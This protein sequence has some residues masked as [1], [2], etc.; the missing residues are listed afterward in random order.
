MKAS[1]IVVAAGSGVR[2]GAST[3]KAFVRVGGSTIL[4]LTLR[5]VG[6]VPSIGEIVLT[7]PPRMERAAREEAA[8]LELP[9]KIIAGGIERQDSVRLALAMTSAEAEL[10][11]VHDV[12]RP[13]ATAAMFDAALERAAEVG[14]AIVAAPL[15]DT[16]KQV[17]GETI[18]ATVLR[19]NLW[20]AQTPQAFR[21][22]LLIRAHE[23][24]SRAGII[25]TD[26]ADLVERLGATVA[27]V[28]GSSMN[29]KITTPEDL[30]LAEAIAASRA[31][32]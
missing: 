13:F 12:A 28:A 32:A 27:I 23:A 5:T 8:G 30:R 1:A 20:L 4:A 11:V 31:P 15:A 9:L 25:A 22:R 26:D 18:R 6:A 2:L 19:A 29:L 3:P 10:V 17:A 7:V 16:L 14:A 24:A 21:R